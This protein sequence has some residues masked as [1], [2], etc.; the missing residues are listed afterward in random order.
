MPTIRQ[1]EAFRAVMETGSLSRAAEI[2]LVTQPA[3][4]KIIQGL[5]AETGL[6]LFTRHRQRLHPTVEAR[7][8]LNE[9]E[10]VLHS[11][12]RVRRIS[13]DLGSAALS[14]LTISAMAAAGINLLPKLLSD[15]QKQYPGSRS[16]LN[17]RSS[18][19]LLELA[20]AQQFDV[21]FGLLNL[22][23]HEVHSRHL[24]RLKAVVILPPDHRLEDA[25]EVELADLRGENF[26]SLGSYDRTASIVDRVFE[27][28]GISRRIVAQVELAS[29]ICEY[30]KQGAGVAIIDPLTAAGCMAQGLTQK[31]LTPPVF[32]DMYMLLPVRRPESLVRE[33]FLEFLTETLHRQIPAET[34]L[35]MDQDLTASR[36]CPIQK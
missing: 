11:L 25:D 35:L 14:D 27:R 23:H 32:F 2:M 7:I 4:S 22:D 16:T 12:E 10:N 9:A 17:I 3:M 19:K 15:F 31:L 21:G 36:S 30:V 29:A 8:L 5:E 34:C 6:Q 18:P 26:I 24:M 1:L 20:V 13:H 33:R 28:A